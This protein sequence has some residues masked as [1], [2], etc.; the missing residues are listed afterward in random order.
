MQHQELLN[1]KRET[2]SY[3]LGLVKQTKKLGSSLDLSPFPK[4]CFFGGF[5]IFLRNFPEVFGLQW[6][7]EFKKELMINKRG[8]FA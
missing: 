5:D 2:G 7:V 3:Y 6:L 8:N 4:H 1:F